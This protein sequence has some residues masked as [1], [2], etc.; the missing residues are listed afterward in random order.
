[1]AVEQLVQADLAARGIRAGIRQLEMGSFLARARATPKQF[2]LLVTGIPGDLSLAYLAGMY[3]SRLAG[4]ALDYGGYHTPRLDALL[5][6]AREASDP[7]A[8]R[9][10][11]HAV[12]RELA[13]E[14]PAAWLYHSRG[15][16]GASRRLTGVTMDLRGELV[17]VAR[18]GVDGRQPSALGPR[19]SATESLE[20][21]SA[22]TRP[23][24]SAEGREPRA[25]GTQQAPRD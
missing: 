24:A 20:A 23:E 17:T 21:S 12:Q 11:W 14:L 16:Q 5:Q 19:L 1:V 4:G 9:D 25:E 13:R 3:D 7:A 2:D 6:A 8:Q 18:W 10:A 15:V 22:P